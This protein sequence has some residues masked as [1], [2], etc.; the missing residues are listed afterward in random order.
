MGFK[1][2]ILNRLKGI[3]NLFLIILT[4]ILIVGLAQNVVRMKKASQ[5]VLEAEM[6][7]EKVRRENE[8]LRAKLNEVQGEEYIEKQLRDK[9]GLAKEGEIVIVLPDEETLRKFAPKPVEEEETLP[10]PTWRKWVKL[11]Y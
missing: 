4:L 5:R 6:R 3:S 7:V 8:E 1:E 11:F 2:S 10:D 9:L